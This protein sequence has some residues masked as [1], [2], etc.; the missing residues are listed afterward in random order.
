M[1]KNWNEKSALRAIN[2]LMVNEKLKIIQVAGMSGL[3]ACSARDYLVNKHGYV[4]VSSELFQSKVKALQEEEKK[5]KAEE[6]KA[7]KMANPQAVKAKQ[8]SDKKAN[9]A[10]KNF[11]KAKASH[12]SELKQA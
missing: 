2:G 3:T 9:K 6:A 8:R 12:K 7:K 11:N 1:S 4:V 5:M 10:R